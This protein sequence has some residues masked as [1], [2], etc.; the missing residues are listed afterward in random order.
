M[1]MTPH[2]AAARAPRPG[3]RRPVVL[4]L[5]ARVAVVAGLVLATVGALAAPLPATAGTVA[6]AAAPAASQTDGPPPSPPL[7]FQIAAEADG[8][9]GAGGQLVVAMSVDNP[10]FSTA[11]RGRV[12]IAVS[13]EPLASRSD[14]ADWLEGDSAPVL[15]HLG[16]ESIEGV[17]ARGRTS[18]TVV[19]DPGEDLAPGVY[20]IRGAYDS[21][22]GR[23]VS[24]GV[25]VV[26]Q[27]DA[28][29]EVAVVVPITAGPRSSGLLSADELT[30]LTGPGGDLR[31]QIDAVV[32]SPVI[33][34]IDP[35]I[36]ASIRVLGT[37]APES[38]TRWLN[39]LL[40]LPHTRFSLQFGDADLA[41]Q[42]AAGLT[43]PLTVDDLSPA[44]DPTGFTTPAPDA[45]PAPDG[46][47]PALPDIAALTDIGRARSD[48]FWPAGGTA[49]PDLIAALDRAGTNAAGSLTLVPSDTVRGE[50]GARATAREADLLV[51]DADVSAALRAA[52]TADS[53]VARAAAV[54][55]AS[56]YGAFADP[57]APLLVTIDR[58]ADRSV[59]ALRSAVRAAARLD[60]R[61]AIGLE[62]L[63]VASPTPVTV[64][65]VAP[66]ATRAS[67]LE[68]FLRG[69]DDLAQ[70]ATILDDPAMLLAPER[71]D[72]LQLIGNGWLPSRAL[73]EDAVDAHR[74]E[75]AETLGAVSII[76][77]PDI[78]LLGA[79]AP[80]SF[81]VRNDLPWPATLV[82]ITEPTDLRLVVQ[83]S[84]DVVA[85][86][87]QTTRVDVPVQARVGSGE[88]SL[89][90]QLRS[91]TMIPIGGSVTIAVAVRAEWETV[92]IVVMSVL[93]GGLLALGIVRTVLR[94]RRRGAG[95]LH[96]DPVA[97]AEAAG[98]A[99]DGRET[100]DV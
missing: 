40:A 85:G 8:V 68:G 14:V 46:G 27:E 39:D 5:P 20:A 98:V 55:E 63:T 36:V 41:V 32:G 37:N 51:Y 53:G 21:A 11:R 44:L 49:G 52:S 91:P 82:L 28:A 80:L 90:L 12:D 7:D 31:G 71:A 89:D 2:A 26:P 35:S 33:L 79:S 10:G 17:A 94:L 97:D 99:K 9:L 72:I 70:F 22:Q 13:R 3:P 15:R 81:S 29:G 83:S 56:A 61:T 38:A 6:S 87:N 66:D 84:T 69:E 95:E 76:P 77:S 88:S 78:N 58:G 86:E 92:G 67:V 57:T 34:A 48:V 65:D 50:R 96:E 16:S 19:L 25:W 100:T 24:R 75:T 62:R 45:T 18:T 43:A 4:R 93:V 60:G 42:Y 47:E 59:E 73:W 74:T 64:T 30:A 54:A 23:L 1:T